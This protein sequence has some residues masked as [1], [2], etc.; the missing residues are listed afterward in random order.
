MWQDDVGKVY[1]HARASVVAR[2]HKSNTEARMPE[3]V[4][5]ALQ[6]FQD[7]V[8]WR[9]PGIHNSIM[10]LCYIGVLNT[11]TSIALHGVAGEFDPAQALVDFGL[12]LKGFEAGR[13]LVVANVVARERL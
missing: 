3:E 4:Q 2:R 6:V 10:V 11:T 8:S 1:Q 7:Q 12:H 13:V 9:H 5:L